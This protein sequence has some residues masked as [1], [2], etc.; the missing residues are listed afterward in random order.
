M[1]AGLPTGSRQNFCRIAIRKRKISGRARPAPRHIRFPVDTGEVWH[2]QAPPASPP[3]LATQVPSLL[4]QTWGK[5]HEGIVLELA[6]VIQKIGGI[7]MAR[8]LE[9]GG[10]PVCRHKQGNH[11]CALD[12]IT[13]RLS[14][15]TSPRPFLLL[16]LQ[17]LGKCSH[18]ATPQP[19]K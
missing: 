16:A 9:L 13:H 14:V 4:A 19:L 6:V 12:S 15:N 7:E 8:V 1:L 11:E 3:V 2:E 5:G 10:I 17:V 18:I